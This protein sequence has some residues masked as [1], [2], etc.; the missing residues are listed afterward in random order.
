MINKTMLLGRKKEANENGFGNPSRQTTQKGRVKDG[1]ITK[2]R[3][4][5][6]ERDEMW[7]GYRRILAPSTE[8]G[9][10]TTRKKNRKVLSKLQDGV[11]VVWRKKG[12]N[13]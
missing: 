5:T 1:W 10:E 12:F 7:G 13:E 3:G 6:R 2:H 4:Q 11:Y 9:T 8:Q